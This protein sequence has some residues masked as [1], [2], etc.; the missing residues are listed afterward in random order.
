MKFKKIT[1]VITLAALIFELAFPVA[2]FAQIAT[3][4][5]STKV[6]IEVDVNDD[7]VLPEI[8]PNPVL[9]L[10][11]ASDTSANF[12]SPAIFKG[13]S[14]RTYKAEEEVV[15]LFE[16]AV[17]AKIKMKLKQKENEI[18]TKIVEV[19]QNNTRFFK[20][21]PPRQFTPGVFT[22]VIE[23][24]HG[25]T[26]EQDFTWGVLAMN[27]NKSVYTPSEKANLSFAVLDETGDMVCDA[28]LYLQITTPS[29][30]IDELSIENGITVNPEC[31]IHDYT[32]RPDYEAEYL[33]E[34]LGEYNFLLTSETNNGSYSIRDRI[35]VVESVDFSVE[36][37]TATRIYPVKDYPVTFKIRAN[38]DF[39]GIVQEVVPY[40]FNI[41]PTKDDEL[42]TYSKVET[43]SQ[44][45]L[46]GENLLKK[47]GKLGLP[48]EGDETLTAEFGIRHNDHF[49]QQKYEEN[50]VVGHDGVD[51]D[52]R[53]G[54]EVLAT[55]DGKIV[56]AKENS[57]YGT[58]VVIE[59]SWG[60]S[61]YGHLS[62]MLVEE[63][64]EVKK[65]DVIALSGNTGLSTN[66]HLHFG[67][68]PEIHDVN[69]G[70]FGKIDPYQFLFDDIS[71]EAITPTENVKVLTFDV[72]LKKG[73]EIS[74]S[75]IYDAPNVSPQ[76]YKLGEARL[77]DE[78]GN[79]VFAEDRQWQIASDVVETVRPDGDVTVGT[80]FANCVTNGN[81]SCRFGV[82]DE[83]TQITG[84]Y[85]GTGT[86]GGGSEQERF[87]MTSVAGTA[88]PVTQVQVSFQA[89]SNGGCNSTCDY[90]SVDISIDGGL[91]GAQ[92]QTMTATNTLYT[93]TYSGSW[94]GDN[95]LEVQFTRTV[96][97]SGNPNNRDDDVR[98]YQ[99]YA[100]VTYTE[101]PAMS[102]LM[103]HGAWFNSVGTKRPFTF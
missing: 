21:E 32:T 2:S 30:T 18:N 101:D 34:D 50:G 44:K 9:D 70:F 10:E 48:F 22:L 75:Y 25:Q 13:L 100:S 57:D 99:V 40:D 73:E 64:T 81:G 20:V 102:Q 11:S 90:L 41:L 15:A 67:I 97:G 74:L 89:H 58:T 87:T 33:F 38:K 46:E 86:A 62:E 1:T 26:I 45:T 76:F 96:Q 77:I 12:Y 6:L 23:D 28:S 36:R 17:N 72:D 93:L 49:I 59:H 61:Y 24:E 60:K 42:N 66:P 3:E 91:V 63:G 52:M 19:I 71:E 98:I 43:Y 31:F 69:N 54:T 84:D 35:E 47:L 27:F 56:H 80:N 16:N 55:D 8:S 14:K 29:G 4:A 39:K 37:I 65:G 92:T 85:V 88:N 94:T 83:A 103:R 82:V 95:D 53:V 79:V 51:F 68:K 7:T 78:T 5:A